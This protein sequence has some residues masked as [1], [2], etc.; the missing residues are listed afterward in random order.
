MLHHRRKRRVRRIARL[1]APLRR[2][3]L[4]QHPPHVRLRRHRHQRLRPRLNAVVRRKASAEMA[5]LKVVPVVRHPEAPKVVRPAVRPNRRVQDPLLRRPQLSRKLRRL[6]LQQAHR[7]M[8]HL[9]VV[10]RITLPHRQR[11]LTCRRPVR[12]ALG[13]PVSPVV[14]KAVLPDKPVAMAG[15][16][17]RKVGLQEDR[18]VV[19]ARRRQPM[20][21]S[22]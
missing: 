2:R 14:H 19:P 11:G 10:P 1:S 6:R 16:V 4:R 13:L 12:A 22:R 17:V 20:L 15:P 5:G 21:A 9:P 8:Q 3:H 18:K 7:P